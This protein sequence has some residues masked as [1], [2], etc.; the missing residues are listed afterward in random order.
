M[1]C[2]RQDRS[3][4]TRPRPM[5]GRCELPSAACCPAPRSSGSSTLRALVLRLPPEARLLVVVNAPPVP[6]AHAIA[7]QAPGQRGEIVMWRD[8]SGDRALG[9]AFTSL[10]TTATA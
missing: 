3:P 9:E 5:T 10:L 6:R 4:S 1:C 7:E 8:V 2:S